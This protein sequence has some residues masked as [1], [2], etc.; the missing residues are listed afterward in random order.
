MSILKRLTFNSIKYLFPNNKTRK[1]GCMDCC[2]I[3]VQ[4]CINNN[5]HNFAINIVKNQQICVW[6]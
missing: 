6:D 5:N 4:V 1:T 3:A 2:K